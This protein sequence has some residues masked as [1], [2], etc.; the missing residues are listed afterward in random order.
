MIFEKNQNYYLASCLV[1]TTLS[2]Y[3]L[4]SSHCILPFKYSTTVP[5]EQ[6]TLDTNHWILTNDIC[7]LETIHTLDTVL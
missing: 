6:S 5:L 7:P 1:S 2:Y 3:T 4:N